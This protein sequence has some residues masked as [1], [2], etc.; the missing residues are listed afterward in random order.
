VKEK[1]GVAMV[2]VFIKFGGAFITDKSQ[3]ETC[4]PERL[5]RAA[6]IVQKLHSKGIRMV[7]VH[8]AGSFGHFHAKIHNLKKL[9]TTDNQLDSERLLGLAACRESVAS[10]S[11]LVLRAL[12]DA[13]I[14]AVVIDVL[15][16]SS[17][18]LNDEYWKEIAKAVSLVLRRGGVPV[19]RGDALLLEDSMGILS[20]DSIMLELSKLLCPLRACFVTDAPGVFKDW[21]TDSAELILVLNEEIAGL[22]NDDAK[23]ADVTGGMKGKITSAFAIAKETR[24]LAAWIIGGEDDEIILKCIQGEIISDKTERTAG[25]LLTPNK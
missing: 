2:D 22:A 16:K 9:P 3:F 20:G 17:D 5:E 23:V 18:T 8:G 14:P 4:R 15:P 13:K 12:I 10:L 7:L 19:L 24:E 11:R 6:K 21:G 1:Q 25:T